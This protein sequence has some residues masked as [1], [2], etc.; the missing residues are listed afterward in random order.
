MLQQELMT[1]ST[2]PGY[3][4]VATFYNGPPPKI[5]TANSEEDAEYRVILKKISKKQGNWG[6]M[7]FI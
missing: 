6:N 4:N 2:N 1:K 3:A 5:Q 7:K